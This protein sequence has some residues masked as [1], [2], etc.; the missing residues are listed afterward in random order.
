MKSSQWLYNKQAALNAVFCRWWAKVGP[1]RDSLHSSSMVTR[2]A[3]HGCELFSSVKCE[4]NTEVS[5]VS[6]LKNRMMLPSW[7]TG[8]SSVLMPVSV[9]SY[10]HVNLP[11]VAFPASVNCVVIC[12][13]VGVV[14]K[15]RGKWTWPSTSAILFTRLLTHSLTSAALASMTN[16]T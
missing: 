15:G 2:H 5:T 6:V 12:R 14:R 3:V 8:F 7:R 9:V 11:H 13:V 4:L 10:L 16:R 1:P